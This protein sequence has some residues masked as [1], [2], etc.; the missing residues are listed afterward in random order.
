MSYQEI[1]VQQV[2][3]T[4]SLSQNERHTEP[5][6]TFES[7]IDDVFTDWTTIFS[8]LNKGEQL[9][10]DQT[11]ADLEIQNLEML[12]LVG[13]LFDDIPTNPHSEENRY[14]KKSYHMVAAK[15]DLIFNPQVHFEFRLGIIAQYASDHDQEEATGRIWAAITR[16]EDYYIPITQYQREFLHI[17]DSLQF[18]DAELWTKKH[19]DSPYG[20]LIK[21]NIE[22]HTQDATEIFP[23]EEDINGN[24]IEIP[25]TL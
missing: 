7:E 22:R 18:Y 17:L 3:S 10:Q 4:A 5:L 16:L 23:N 24:E 15:P 12:N 2:I 21:K 6:P 8:Y 25:T 20:E 9:W 13:S 1:G 19:P 14:I 11:N